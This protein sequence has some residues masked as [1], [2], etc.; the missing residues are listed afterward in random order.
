MK[1]RS[2]LVGVMDENGSQSVPNVLVIPGNHDINW[3]ILRSQN[4]HVSDIDA[5]SSSRA[6]HYKDGK[7]GLRSELQFLQEYAWIPFSRLPFGLPAMTRD[8]AWAPGYCVKDLS[9]ELGVI[10]VCVNSSRWGV[11]HLEQS[12]EVPRET[13]RAIRSRLEGLDP[14]HVAARILLVHHSLDYDAEPVNRLR[15]P[16]AE[17]ERKQLINVIN[18]DCRFAFMLTGHLHE[19]CATDLATGTA[20]R[21]LVHIGAGTAQSE[22][23]RKYQNPEF[24][25]V[26][27]SER[28]TDTNKFEKLTVYTFAWNG[29]LFQQHSGFRDGTRNFEVFGLRY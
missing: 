21:K 20:E 14:D 18:G 3:D 24:N 6:L 7:G 1:Q 26:R 8:W 10:F 28:S 15:L 17:D 2:D 25:I 29:R 16:D 27:L 9:R 22:D 12:G 13:W 5:D 19:C 11:S 4:I 23:R